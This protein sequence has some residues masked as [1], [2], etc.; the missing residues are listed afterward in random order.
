MD[1]T[2]QKS[3]FFSIGLHLCILLLAIFGLPQPKPKE[4]GRYQSVPVEI[5]DISQFTNIKKRAEVRKEKPQ[6]VLRPKKATKSVSVKKD[7]SVKRTEKKLV[8][9]QKIADQLA[10]PKEVVSEK[11][12]VKKEEIKKPLDSKE[13]QQ[14]MTE[15]DDAHFDALLK[16]IEEKN[17]MKAEI[18]VQEEKI[19]LQEEKIT[20][21]ESTQEALS[22][23]LTISE[24]DMLRRQIEQCWNVP[25]GARDAENL[26]V[27]VRIEMNKDR[28]VKR[29]EIINAGT[30]MHTNHFYRVAAE[31]ARRAVLN[32]RCSPLKLPEN[33][34]HEWRVFVISFNPKEMLEA[35]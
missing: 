9:K 3:L 6:Q 14:K 20:P 7:L 35:F 32:P 27:E 13:T 33:K 12:A 31:S 24:E 23:R 25:S 34:Y 8:Q 29:A 2:P 22:N 26:Q 16:D 1:R 17:K 21:I 5:V 19:D 15:V 30:R 11:I 4:V 28:T 18:D 10:K